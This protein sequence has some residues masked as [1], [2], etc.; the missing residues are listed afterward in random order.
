MVEQ[1]L[2]EIVGEMLDIDPA[3]ISNSANLI[4]DLAADSL[5]QVEIV[6]AIEEEFNISIEEKEYADNTTIEQIVKLI[7][8]KKK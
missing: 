5:D 4:E 3:G 7:E 8:D 6:M 1:K 2:K